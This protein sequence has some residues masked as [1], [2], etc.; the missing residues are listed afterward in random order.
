MLPLKRR[1]KEK[2]KVFVCGCSREKK[3]R[4]KK[5]DKKTAYIP[6]LPTLENRWRASSDAL[7]Y[8]MG[9]GARG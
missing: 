9:E 7:F 8:E 1:R 5:Y 3:L 6:L 2:G 4:E